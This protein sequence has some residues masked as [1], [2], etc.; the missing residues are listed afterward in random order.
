MPAPAVVSVPSV[1]PLSVRTGTGPVKLSDP[2]ITRNYYAGYELALELI[3]KKQSRFGFDVDPADPE[4][5]DLAQSVFGSERVLQ[6]IQTEHFNRAAY[7]PVIAEEIDALARE[8]YPDVGKRRF[9]S[10]DKLHDAYAVDLDGDTAMIGEPSVESL[11]RFEVLDYL[12]NKLSADNLRYLKTVFE[13]RPET[14]EFVWN[15]RIYHLIDASVEYLE[16][17]VSEM[18]RLY[19]DGV[20]F[21]PDS[22]VA[23][24]AL[25]EDEIVGYY[26][27]VYLGLA[28][29]FPVNFLAFDT[30]YRCAVLTRYAV[31]AILQ[32]RPLDV[33]G[34]CSPA[35][36][37]FIGLRGVVRH[38]NYS[39]NRMIRNAY[40]DVLMPWEMGHVEDGFWDTEANRISAIRWL[41]EEKLHIARPDIP[42]ALRANRIRK[43]TFAEH[44][45]SYLF[46]RH[47]KSVSRCIGTAYPEL[48][49]WELGSVP[50]SYWQG[51]EGATR[52]AEAVRWFVATLGIPVA[53][54]PERIKDRTISRETFAAHGLSTVFERIYKKNM[55]HILN[56]AYPG[57]F[58]IWELGKV[59]VEHWENLMNAYRAALWVARREGVDF[60]ALPA[61]IRTHKLKKEHF[62]KYGLGGMLKRCFEDDLL[63]AYLPYLLPTR[64]DTE[65]LMREVV[66]LSALHKQMREL[67][68]GPAVLRAL[69]F[70]PFVVSPFERHQ[71]RLYERMKKRIT[72]RIEELGRALG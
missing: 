71:K 22:L 72:Q 11:S 16:A 13:Q 14:G 64:Q 29:K 58:E 57:R 48:K 12:R 45:L 55:F 59:P 19:P 4:Y 43:A 27:N 21:D 15:D 66:L 32:K 1:L 20:P 53:S 39:I 28:A 36:F 9:V 63:K 70:V 54:I 65:A 40:P 42:K 68:A 52:C 25:T 35:D 24:Q 30:L 69:R 37:A 3:R 10:L 26:K 46:V 56:A 7:E 50:N 47:Y 62:S 5:L 33:L 38:F 18:R 23:G 31:E 67:R 49:P 34:E 60:R 61:A 44:G 6:L 17:K 51:E 8:L 2:E 41:V